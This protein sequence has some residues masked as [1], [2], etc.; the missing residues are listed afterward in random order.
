MRPIVSIIIPTFN[1]GSYIGDTLENVRKQTFHN[2]ECVVLDDGSTDST[3]DIVHQFIKK[4]PRIRYHRQEN[5]GLSAARNSAIRI[6]N[7]IFIQLLDADD[8]LS[9]FKLE[10]QVPYME[11]RPEIGISY[12]EAFYFR[13]G[14]PDEKIRNFEY[15]DVGE[16]KL[17]DTQWIPQVD[18]TDRC[19]LLAHLYHRNLAPVNSMLIRKDVFEAVGLF[20]ESFSLLE[21][22]H[23]F[24]RA[25]LHGTRFTYF[26]DNHAYAKVRIHKDSMSYQ[27]KEMA[28][29]YMKMMLEIER[30]I[31][32]RNLPC[33]LPTEQINYNGRHFLR[34][35]GLSN[36][37]KTLS[38]AKLLGWRR[39]LRL[40]LKE[41]NVARKRIFSFNP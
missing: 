6:A 31:R 41:L 24:S 9:P 15:I 27:G 21:D 2:W 38:L 39:T 1:Y 13:H 7:G 23:F 22:W 4:D 40:Y 17:N 14:N 18:W 30:G 5:K 20:D 10:R 26:R 25:A 3:A 8:L 37:E 29:H 19:K 11:S 16:F 36:A 32:S 33:P 35:H 28:F 12:T 34:R